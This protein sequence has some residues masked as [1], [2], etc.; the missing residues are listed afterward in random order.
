MSRIDEA[1]LRSGARQRKPDAGVKPGP[2]TFDSPWASQDEP[3]AR[4]QAQ[5][6]S[7][8]L[9]DSP[10]FG[11]PA[12]KAATVRSPLSRFSEAWRKRLS[13]GAEK[14]SFLADQ[15]ERLGATLLQVRRT[16][17]LQTVMV[18]SA[19]PSDGK[20]LTSLN[21]ALVLSESYR[22]RVL[23]VD[24]DL[25]RPGI[26]AAL[27]LPAVGGLGEALRSGE[28]VGVDYVQLSDRLALLP[29]GRPE[30]DP[31][32]GLSSDRLRT[33]LTGAAAAFDWII[34]DTP[35]LGATADATLLLPLVDAVLLVVRASKTSYRAVQSAIDALGQD[36]ILGVILNASESAP[37]T[38]YGASYVPYGSAPS[39]DE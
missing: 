28:T 34:V 13:V 27:G 7:A 21:V 35:P 17:K 37:G 14:D 38:S 25:R 22:K 16:Q 11:A 29:A 4:E 31:L 32:S 2:G 26:G 6:T 24:C 15:F 5:H 30:L 19:E 8:Q 12:E 9:V 23:L 36:R 20:T 1:L 3:P 18:T 10:K 33:I 39:R